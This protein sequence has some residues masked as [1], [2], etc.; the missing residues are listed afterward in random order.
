MINDILDLS[1]I[2]SGKF[3]LEEEQVDLSDIINRC[4]RMIRDRAKAAQITVTCEVDPKLSLLWADER[5]MMQ[6]LLNLLSNS[7]KFSPA[8]SDVRLT[9]EETAGHLD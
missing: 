5:A 9:A 2:E 6:I 7:V 4:L 8:N 3:E 1:K